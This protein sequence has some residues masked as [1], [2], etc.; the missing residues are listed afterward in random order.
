MCFQRESTVLQ[1]F[2]GKPDV[3][4]CLAPRDYSGPRISDQAIS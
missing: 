1:L 3:L 4:Q 2:T